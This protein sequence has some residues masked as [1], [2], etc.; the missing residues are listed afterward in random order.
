MWNA[1]AQELRVSLWIN[2]LVN[3]YNNATSYTIVWG[4]GVIV[5]VIGKLMKTWGKVLAFTFTT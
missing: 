3:Y 4:Q 5:E 1:S 2:A